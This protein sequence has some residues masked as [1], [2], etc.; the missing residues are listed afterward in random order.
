MHRLCSLTL[1]CNW[2][3]R[4]NG[5]FLCNVLMLIMLF[6]R[7]WNSTLSQRIGYFS[8]RINLFLHIFVCILL[9]HFC[10]TIFTA[11]EYC[12]IYSMWI[13]FTLCTYPLH[14]F[15]TNLYNFCSFLYCVHIL[16]LSPVFIMCFAPCACIAG[17]VHVILT[18]VFPMSIIFFVSCAYI[19]QCL[20]IFI[21]CV[22]PACI[23][24]CVT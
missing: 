11:W 12:H 20:Q 19:A 22:L 10:A 23:I 5:A 18:A 13:F 14:L 4:S 17:D 6:L 9:T 1:L 3:N 21:Y 15:V 16:N 2:H 8:L 24:Y 7:V